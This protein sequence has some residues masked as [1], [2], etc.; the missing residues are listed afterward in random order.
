MTI[1]YLNRC[2]E[3]FLREKNPSLQTKLLYFLKVTSST[4]WLGH[5]PTGKQQEATSTTATTA[6]DNTNTTT[7]T[8]DQYTLMSALVSPATH[9]AM[10]NNHYTEDSVMTDCNASTDALQHLLNFIGAHRLRPCAMC[11]A[12][13]SKKVLCFCVYCP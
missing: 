11:I 2:A 1:S 3:E 6:T 13:K 5:I 9:D 10:A 8:T 12:K 7:A 4:F